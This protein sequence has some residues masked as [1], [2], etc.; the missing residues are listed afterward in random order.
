MKFFFSSALLNLAVSLSAL[1][2][3]P[4][5]LSRVRFEQY[6]G[7]QLSPTLVFRDENDEPFRFND[8]LA[9]QKQP[10]IL[11]LGYYRCPMLCTLINNGLI[12]TLQELRMSVGLD[13]QVI[14]VSIDPKE[15]PEDAA[16]KKVEYLRHYGRSGASP[17]WHCL[18]G[19]AETIQQ[20]ADSVGYRYVYD[21]EI[22]QYAHP[23]GVIL[24]TPDGTISRYFFG[25]SFRA[26]EFRDG[27][28]VAREGRS[29]SVMSQVLL[30]C[31]HYNPIT[32][33]YG[34]GILSLMR[35]AAVVT[36][37]AVIGAVALMTGRDRVRNSCQ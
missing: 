8:R 6:P 31:Y 11:V 32:G 9:E 37:L 1:A 7:R 18:T 36:I 19:D 14:N 33:R 12:Q 22:K 27:L 17:G 5:D 4:A 26:K 10:V 28:V 13:F 15:T 24:L 34:P 23:S 16:A 25:V 29:S 20:L 3:N 21:P 2:L 30:L 35:G